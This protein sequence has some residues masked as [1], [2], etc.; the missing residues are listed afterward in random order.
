MQPLWRFVILYFTSDFAKERREKDTDLPMQYLSLLSD[1]GSDG[2]TKWQEYYR[3]DYGE[4]LGP[5]NRLLLEEALGQGAFSTVYRCRDM[6]A[7]QSRIG[8]CFEGLRA[9]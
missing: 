1:T 9:L 2:P 6:K 3:G 5:E 4:P 7:K 8:F